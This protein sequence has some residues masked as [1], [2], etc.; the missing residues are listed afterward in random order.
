MDQLVLRARFEE[1]KSKELESIKSAAPCKSVNNGGMGGTTA[2]VTTKESRSKNHLQEQTQTRSSGN[3]RKCFNC[4]LEG[5]LV[6]ECPYPKSMKRNKE[7]ERRYRDHH[8]DRWDFSIRPSRGP[9]PTT[10]RG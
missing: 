3:A 1:A 8:T 2:S 7:S 9:A 5:H 6:R 4:R 10:P